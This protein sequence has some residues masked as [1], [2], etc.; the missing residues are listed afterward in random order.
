[1]QKKPENLAI[2][3]SLPISLEGEVALKVVM[4]VPSLVVFS[5]DICAWFMH[6]MPGSD[7][8]SKIHLEA[9]R[10]SEAFYKNPNIKNVFVD[11]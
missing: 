2:T 9:G 7:R 3:V 5:V 11:L 8:R 4:H 1:M 10:C 6:L